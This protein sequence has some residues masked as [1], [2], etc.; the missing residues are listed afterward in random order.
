MWHP[1]QLLRSWWVGAFQVPWLPEMALRAGGYAWL[2]RNL[3]GSARPGAFPPELLERY[4]EQWARPGALV[5]MLN[6]FRAMALDPPTPALR[7]D[8]PVTVL[9]GEQDRFLDR[10][11]ADAA[12]ALCRRGELVAFPQATHWL[13]HEERDE[14]NRHL[15]KALA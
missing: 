5:A 6:W 11:L 12:L 1:G 14:V 9:W 2:E 8:L 3:L 10:G 7:I 13:H 15:L 4:R